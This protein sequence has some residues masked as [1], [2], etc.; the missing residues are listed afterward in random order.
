MN[1]RL[2]MLL[3]S[4]AP[5]WIHAQVGNPA[6]DF[7]VTDTE[8]E[9]HQLYDYVEAGKVVVLDFYYTTCG[10]CQFYS[11]QVNLAYQKYGCNT[12]NVVFIS[13]DYNDSDA[14]V[15]AYDSEYSIEFPSVSGLEGGGNDV[16][17]QYGILGFPTFYVIDS[18][19]TIIDVIDP[20]TLQVFDF[21]FGH[22]GIVPADCNA[23][24]NHEISDVQRIELYPNPV[25]NG[26]ELGIHL[27]VVEAS[28]IRYEIFN[29]L[30]QVVQKGEMEVNNATTI[31]LNVE[32]LIPGIYRVSINPKVGAGMFYG[33]F[34]KE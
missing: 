10:P 8:G 17:S 3:F 27:P 7:T 12:A 32:N 11:P 18:T 16:V 13:I 9:T 31:A 14:E 29:L 24:A 4:C 1:F 33:F 6:S 22:H 19:K 21:R 15:V 23:S 2:Y 26:E 5:L 30:G 20:P 28:M 34:M 25:S